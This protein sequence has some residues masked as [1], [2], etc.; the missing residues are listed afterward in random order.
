MLYRHSQKKVCGTAP[1]GA[2]VIPRHHA[3]L[4]AMER[5]GV[6]DGCIRHA[7]MLG[8]EYYFNNITPRIPIFLYLCAII[9]THRQ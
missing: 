5:V 2:A 4:C 6:Y 8:A 3:L 7:E 9:Y 1:K